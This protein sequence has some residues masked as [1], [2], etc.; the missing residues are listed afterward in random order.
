MTVA[1]DTAIRQVSGISLGVS[2]R[3]HMTASSTGHPSPHARERARHWWVGPQD[4]KFKPAIAHM[5]GLLE[6]TTLHL[7]FIFMHNLLR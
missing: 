6:R 1:R 2:Q 7:W 4:G 5:F 3:R